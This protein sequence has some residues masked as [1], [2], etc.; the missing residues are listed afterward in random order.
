MYKIDELY[1][2]IP[3]AVQRSIVY[4]AILVAGEKYQSFTLLGFYLHQKKKEAHEL[5]WVW[6]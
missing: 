2:T 5:K 4:I 3:A 6:E 1:L